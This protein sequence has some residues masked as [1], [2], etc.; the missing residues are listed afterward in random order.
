MPSQTCDK[1]GVV[2]DTSEAMSKHMQEAHPVD[3]ADVH[4][5]PTK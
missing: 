3:P 1:C 2:L 4:S 5:V